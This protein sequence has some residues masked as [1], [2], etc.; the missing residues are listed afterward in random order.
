MK[1][2]ALALAV[3]LGACATVPAPRDA[4]QSVYALESALTTA[5][6]VATVYASLPRCSAGGAALCS[7]AAIVHDINL[8][9]QAAGIA[10]ETA[11]SVVTS[12]GASAAAQAQAVASAQAA[13]TALTT[14]TSKVKISP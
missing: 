12:G 6:Q 10:V 4:A 14:L 8:A 11:Q 9:A 13:V 7:D 2:I 3:A 5:V 1:I